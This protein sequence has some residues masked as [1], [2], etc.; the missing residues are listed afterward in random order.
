M[1]VIAKTCINKRSMTIHDRIFVYKAT[2]ERRKQDI[3]V[4]AMLFLVATLGLG[5]GYIIGRDSQKTPIIIQKCA[6]K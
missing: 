4:A 1:L 2:Y 5:I 3:A 6:S